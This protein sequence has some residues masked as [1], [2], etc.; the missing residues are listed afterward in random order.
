MLGPLVTAA[1]FAI[2]GFSGEGSSYWTG[3]LPGLIVVGIGMTLSVPPLT[4]T[5]FN[6]APDVS[7]G[8]ASGINNA[9][10]RA[11]GLVAI[12]MLGLAFGTSGVAGIGV[13]ALASAYRLVMFGAAVL[14]G[15]SAVT[16]AFTINSRQDRTRRRPS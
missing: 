11:G 9:A 16:A 1:G 13:S 10:A 2:L 5:V 7:S 14:A 3:F 15:L 8:T 12:A 6:S 4:T